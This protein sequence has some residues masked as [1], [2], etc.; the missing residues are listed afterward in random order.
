MKLCCLPVTSTFAFLKPA[1]GNTP[2]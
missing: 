2:S 1:P